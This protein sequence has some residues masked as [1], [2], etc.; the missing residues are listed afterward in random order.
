MQAEITDINCYPVKSL[1]GIALNQSFVDIIGLRN[2]RQ[3]MLANPQGKFISQ[4]DFPVMAT[5]RTRIAESG[6]L[7]SFKYRDVAKEILLPFEMYEL[8]EEAVS[9]WNSDFIAAGTGTKYDDWFSE[10][11]GQSCKLMYMKKPGARI[12]KLNVSP[13]SVPLRFPDGYPILIA[14]EA[15][16][17]DLNSRIEKPVSKSRFRANIWLKNLP[18]WQEETL[19]EFKIGYLTFKMLKPCA[20]CV[21]INIDQ[22]TGNRS[23]EPLNTL[24]AFRKSGNHVYFGMNAICLGEGII[25]KGQKLSL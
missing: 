10:I 18:P 4:R 5:I 22:E 19:D 12:K 6:I 23:K 11:I 20:R 8:S 25:K 9:V 15:S 13:Y 24:S 7:C 17:E 14:N 21:M 3:W 1:K 2:D 16:L